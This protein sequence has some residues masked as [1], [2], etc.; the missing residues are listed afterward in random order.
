MTDF[1]GFG[2]FPCFYFYGTVWHP[3]IMYILIGQKSLTFGPQ[4][5]VR[6]AWA[7]VNKSSAIDL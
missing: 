3:K 2:V 6:A 7:I 1:I 5:H 4:R